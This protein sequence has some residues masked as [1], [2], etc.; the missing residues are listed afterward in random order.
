MART[1]IESRYASAAIKAVESFAVEA[2]EIKLVTV[3][4][5]VTFRVSARYSETD[6]VLRFHRPGYNSIEELESEKAWVSALS[7][8]GLSVPGSLLTKEGKY[9]E[10]VDIPGEGKPL[11]V[12]M[13]T[14]FEGTVLSDYLESD[15]TSDERKQIF[16]RIGKIA[17][18]IHNQAVHWTEPPGFKRRRLDLD[19]LLG[20]TPHWGRF[21]EHAELTSAEQELLLKA[22]QDARISIEAYG[23]SPENFSLIHADLHPDNIVY[24][25]GQLSIID[26]DDAAY[27]WHLY[28]IA[29][30]L[31]EF[32]SAPDFEALCAALLEGYREVRPLSARDLEILPTFLLV[33]GMATIGWFHQRPEHAGSDYFEYLKCWVLDLCQSNTP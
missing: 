15:C 32:G 31:I 18:A 24:N 21:W 29:T 25:D 4:E 7:D 5:N 10:Q 8:A 23:E 20:E 26:F 16:R 6:Y 3:S 27:G 30:V 13:T 28:E 14:W 33:R 17:A 11:N 19:G 1:R 9:F 22:R 2:D 12:G